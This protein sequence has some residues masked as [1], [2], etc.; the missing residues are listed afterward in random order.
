MRRDLE[1]RFGYDLSR[2]RI[3]AGGSA[4]TSA[5]DAGA[6]AYTVGRHIV[7]GPG[8]YEPHSAR[9]RALLVHELTHTIQQGMAEPAPH[10]GRALAADHPAER[11]AARA[12]TPG[13]AAG[14][15]TVRERTAPALA[16]Q[17]EPAPGEAGAGAAAGPV[18]AEAESSG[19]STMDALIDQ[20]SI[21]AGKALST[22]VPIPIPETVL[23]AL[24]A[25]EVAFIARSFRRLVMQSEFLEIVGRVRELA[26]W[27]VAAEFGLRYIWGV[28][29][30]LASPVTG[31]VQFAVSGVELAAAAG[32]WAV[33]HLQQTPE[34]QAEAQGLA[35]DWEKFRTAA[36]ASLKPLQSRQGALEFAGAVFS[37]AEA[38]GAAIERQLVGMARE[39]GSKAADQ[40]VNELRKTPLPE[41][42]ERAGEIVGMVVIEVVMLAFSDGIGNL[43]AKL[44]EFARSLRPLSRGVGAVA[45]VMVG[46][47]RIIAELEHIVGT[48]MSKTVLKPLMPLL[49]ALEPLLA[50]AQKFSQRLLGLSE[51]AA[52]GLGR[53]GARALTPGESSAA[54]ATERATEHAPAPPAPKPSTAHRP[55][56]PPAAEHPPGGGGPGGGGARGATAEGVGE[57]FRYEYHPERPVPPVEP[58]RARPA[59]EPQQAGQSRPARPRAGERVPPAAGPRKSGFTSAEIAEDIA[60]KTRHEPIHGPAE[61]HGKPAVDEPEVREP[62]RMKELD[63]YDGELTYG[64]EG[65]VRL[66]AANRGTWAEAGTEGNSRWTPREP[67][68]YGLEKGQSILFRD[69]V[70]DLS[71]YAVNTPTGQR[72]I[73]RFSRLRGGGSDFLLADQRLAAEAGADW[74]WQRVSQ[75]RRENG[76]TYHHYSRDELQL[77]PQRIHAPLAHQGSSTEL[78]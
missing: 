7:F 48:L 18:A 67:A 9:G 4:G 46:A 61:T 49:E 8:R 36:A 57:E 29:K 55:P 10:G 68:E 30:G 3:H 41:L 76:L 19:S 43:I 50:R 39:R 59:G 22:S 40:L 2:V 74:D 72:G 75:W 26:D 77:V 78:K 1:G 56:R 73:L 65:K 52:T 58:R 15:M 66:P 35:A 23:A 12:A 38:A 47:G 63:P 21:V 11:E 70:P 13:A 54:G 17:A 27:K 69:G 60:E 62:G 28:L 64:P 25:A 51:E 31:L 32:S 5:R 45:D 37:A 20:A 16:R 24:T 34:V 42:A 44:G 14:R 53:A 6:S 33:E 71:E